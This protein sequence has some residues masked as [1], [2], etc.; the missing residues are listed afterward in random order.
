MTLY[1][2]GIAR[3]FEL[4]QGLLRSVILQD[5]AAAIKEFGY[6]S[7][8]VLEAATEEQIRVYVASGRGEHTEGI[9]TK[10]TE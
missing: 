9:E 5:Y 8:K 10:D 1:W 6:D 3:L 4:I 7:F 2:S